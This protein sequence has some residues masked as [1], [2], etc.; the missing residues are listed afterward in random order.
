MRIC[1]LEQQ[2][3][4]V[5]NAGN[6]AI[7]DPQGYGGK[8]YLDYVHDVADTHRYGAAKTRGCGS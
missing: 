8:P 1:H 5:V 3:A 7:A 2:N 4:P 6:T